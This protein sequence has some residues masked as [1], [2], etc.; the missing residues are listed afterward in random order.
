MNPY[1]LTPEGDLPPNH[2]LVLEALK[3]I[4]SGPIAELRST[5]DNNITNPS[6]Q[7]GLKKGHIDYNNI[8][9]NQN[10]NRINGLDDYSR[11]VDISNQILN[12]VAPV[13][14]QQPVKIIHNASPEVK[15]DDSHDPNQME[16][17]LFKPMEVSDLHNKLFAIEKKL[18]AV[19]NY[20][21]NNKN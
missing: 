19:L 13:Q 16:L 10:Q 9:P 2:P 20:V 1:Q 17:P 3:G 8:L 14:Y 21:K 7:T 6:Y 11:S 18:D 12:G 5:V 4:I 15:F